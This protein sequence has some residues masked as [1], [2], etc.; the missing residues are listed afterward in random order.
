MFLTPDAEPFW[1][2]TY[3]P[4]APRFGR[5]GF[6]QVLQAVHRAWREKRDEIRASAAALSGHVGARLAAPPTG[7]GFSG[8]RSRRWPKA[9]WRMIDPVEGG[10]QGAPKFPNAPLMET[11]WLSWLS[12]GDRPGAMPSC[13]ARAR[14]S[15][16]AIY[17]HLGGGLS[18]YSTDAGWAVPHF[19][20]MLYDNAQLIRLASWAY[21]E[22]EEELFRVRIEETIGW[23]DREMG[24]PGGALPP[25][26][27]PTATARKESSTLGLRLDWRRCWAPTRAAFLTDYALATAPHWEGDPVLRRRAFAAE[28]EPVLAP[29]RAKLLAARAARLRPRRDDKVLVDWNGMAIAAIAAAARLFGR[30]DWLQLAR[31]AYADV[32]RFRDGDRLPHAI[33]GEKAAYPG[34]SSDHAGLALAAAA[35]HQ[36]TGGADYT[37]R[38]LGF[39]GALDRW[40]R[41]RR[42]RAFPHGLG[43][44]RRSV[45]DPRRC[46]RSHPVGDQPGDPGQ[47]D[48]GPCWR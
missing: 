37:R 29:L 20:K 31:D 43:Q 15:S 7:G 25:A 46:R 18:R 8:E 16:A 9:L 4:N 42:G 32:L 27:M 41:R 14:C 22:T 33:L 26:S 21:A 12:T 36:A 38:R 19:E 28:R 45:P 3:F 40:Y 2:G 5:P 39:C 10:L 23:L 11:L 47:D 6:P 48:G 1:G 30:D 24:V 17:D 35:L 34:L 44:P 13:C